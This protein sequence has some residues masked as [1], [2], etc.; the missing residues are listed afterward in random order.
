MRAAQMAVK[1]AGMLV[2]L[3]GVL[4]AVLM[5][6]TLGWQTVEMMAPRM[7]HPKERLKAVHWAKAEVVGL[8]E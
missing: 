1:T 6:V 8:V 4:K 5:A 7:D 3:R 2:V